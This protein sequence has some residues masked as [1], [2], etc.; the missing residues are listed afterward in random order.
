MRVMFARRKFRAKIIDLSAAVRTAEAEVEAARVKAAEI[1][2]QYWE[3][4]IFILIF[5]LVGPLKHAVSLVIT[6]ALRKFMISCLP[7]SQET[8]YGVEDIGSTNTTH[9]NCTNK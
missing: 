3:K 4:M 5:I 7:C 8:F 2:K 1:S 9:A 6:I